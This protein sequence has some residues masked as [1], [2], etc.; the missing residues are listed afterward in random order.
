MVEL[1]WMEK[2]VASAG[3]ARVYRLKWWRKGLALFFLVFGLLGV[4]AFWGGTVFG[5]KHPEV[6]GMLAT[7]AITLS[8]LYLTADAFTQTIVLWHDAIEKRTMFVT[9]RLE[10]TRIRG[11]REYDD[12]GYDSTTRYLELVPNDRLLP[13]LT[14]EKYFTFDREFYLWFNSF[15]DLG[16][17]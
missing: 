1:V 16:P 10:F 14:F 4:N 15:P 13:T 17:K 2:G 12:E 8:G 5:G 7:A 11:R 6:W 3:L 9:Q